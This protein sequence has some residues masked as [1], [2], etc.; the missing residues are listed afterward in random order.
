MDLLTHLLAFLVPPPP[1]KKSLPK[2]CIGSPV[3]LEYRVPFLVDRE[4]R[5]ALNEGE[6]IDLVHGVEVCVC[7][8]VVFHVRKVVPESRQEGDQFIVGQEVELD[9]RG[10]QCPMLIPGSVQVFY[11]RRSINAEIMKLYGETNYID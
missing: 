10:L 6:A 8:L 3:F 7:E 5:D 2:Y 1:K 4:R 9:C 11:G